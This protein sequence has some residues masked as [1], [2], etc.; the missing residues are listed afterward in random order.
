MNVVVHVFPGSDG[1]YMVVKRFHWPKHSSSNSQV[2]ED[3][4]P[5]Q[6]TGTLALIKIDRTRRLA[7]YDNLVRV[8][9]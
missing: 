5:R 2:P 1:V 9:T 6:L 8:V 3:R 7:R 4:R